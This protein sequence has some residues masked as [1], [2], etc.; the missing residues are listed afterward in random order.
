MS[1]ETYL[2]L[3]EFLDQ[4]PIGMPET[5]K[6]IEIEILK[7]LFTEE[8]AQLAILLTIN[9]E[10]A[11][12]IARRYKLD[13]EELEQKLKLMADKALIFR[14]RRGENTL[15]RAAPIMIGLYEY[16]TK[17]ID[18]ELAK[19]Y[20]EYYDVALMEEMGASDIPGFKVLPLDETI[21]AETVLFP[22]HKLIES[23]KIARVIAVADCVCRKEAKLNEIGCD[24]P[25]EVCLSFGS[26][27]EF[28][29]E[30]GMGRK[31]SADEAIEILRKTDEA[32]LVHAGVNSKHLSNICN[33]CSCCCA[34]MKGITQHGLDKRKY[35][36]ALFESIIDPEICIGCGICIERCPVEAI[37]QEDYVK[38][39]RNKCLGCGLCAGVCPENAITLKLREDREEP[40]D[41][42]LSLGVA[43][44]E[45]KKNIKNKK[46]N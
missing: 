16:S 31:I 33:C 5:Q 41:G 24:A 25:I 37:S 46:S 2:K 22:Y 9:P 11:S 43:I 45:A 7:K 29:I 12:R 38:V 36:N 3:R 18:H 20:K 23:V 44:L 10:P 13:K 34:S 39:D 35:M 4:F 42:V 40:F 14:I 26:A 32:G 8:E 19:L 30:T 28:Y 15:Y 1:D 21:E 6:G 17:K 27:A